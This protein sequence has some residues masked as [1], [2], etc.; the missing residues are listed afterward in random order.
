MIIIEAPYLS[1]LMAHWLKTSGHPVLANDFA[2][3]AAKANPG[4]HLVSSEEAA[5]RL[6]AGE[7]LYTNSEN[8]LEWVLG[9]TC[10]QPLRDSIKLCKDKAAMRAKLAPLDPT[11]FYRE[12]SWDELRQLDTA[13]LPFPVVVKPTVG[14]ISFGVHVAANADQWKHALSELSEEVAK[15]SLYP[16]SV[17]DSSTFIV[18]GY[19]DGQ[20]YAVDVYFD[21]DGK[22]VILD[23]M[24]HDFRDQDDTSDHLYYTSHALMRHAVPHLAAWF[25][26]ANRFLQFADFCSHVE[27]R[28]SLEA[29]QA[30]LEAMKDPRNIHVIEF[31]PLR[32]A[33]FCGTD[34]GYFAHGLYPYQAY[35]ENQKPTWDDAS[36]DDGLTTAF[37]VLEAPSAQKPGRSF[38]YPLFLEQLRKTAPEL[39]LCDERPLNPAIHG[40]SGF[41]LFKVPTS[42]FST[43]RAFGLSVCANQYFAPVAH[44]EEDQHSRTRML[45]GEDALERLRQ[46]HVCVF[47]VGGVGG[48]AAEALARAGVG[49]ITLV[50]ADYVAES[51]I[52]RQVI[53]T[54]DTIGRP[55]VDVMAERIAD[56]NPHCC[57]IARKCFYLPE[58]RQDF[59]FASYD[60]VVDAIDTVTAKIDLV[61][62][63]H[64]T[65]T[66]II[67]AMGAGNKLDPS[68]FEVADIYSTSVC[69][70]AKVMRKELRARNIP[71]L[72][73]VYSRE[74][75]LK[76][77]PEQE[78]ASKR[79]P[80][81]VS[82]VPGAMGLI[83]AG[84]VIRD[85][86]NSGD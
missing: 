59:D 39:E 7:R 24:Q 62:A 63:A 67:S 21:E 72:K 14:F 16:Q 65:A 15:R 73:C 2:C 57:V 48:H 43:T 27:L 54:W 18:E 17:I 26:E 28:V 46:A 23:I 79:V 84:E 36:A 80:G 58:G 68:R 29:D 10:N 8:A 71:S 74:E 20:E 81:S 13:G 55:K 35:L 47:G 30:P 75:P 60:Y 42:H 78:G 77:S 37:I 50:D 51:N 9:N 52:N 11:L 40:L 64:E 70:L 6:D 32:F 85:L 86:T 25:E 83:L 41:P 31:N 76:P 4:I 33:G 44:N 22:P 56:I 49:T 12:C 1:D 3:Q 82:F 53:A 69:K 45:L 19:I 61:M 38:S 5:Q 34:L 66:P